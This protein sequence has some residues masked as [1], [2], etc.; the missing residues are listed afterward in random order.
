VFGQT[1]T[2][3]CP[4]FEGRDLGRRREEQGGDALADLRLH[5]SFIPPRLLTDRKEP[6]STKDDGLPVEICDE[7]NFVDAASG[8]RS[9]RPDG[10]PAPFAGTGAVVLHALR[11]LTFRGN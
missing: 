5:R 6:I 7:K 9:H 11:I 10:G 2:V 4:P 8:P 3:P 1:P